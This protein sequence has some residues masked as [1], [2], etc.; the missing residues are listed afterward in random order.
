MIV[1]KTNQLR[2]EDKRHNGKQLLNIKRKEEIDFMK[3]I[4]QRNKTQTEVKFIAN[5]IPLNAVKQ[6]KI[7]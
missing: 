3:T 1:K 2:S 5:T 4:D 6:I 7:N